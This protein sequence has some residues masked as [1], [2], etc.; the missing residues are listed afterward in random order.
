MR[1]ILRWA[2]INVAGVLLV[3]TS[4]A[5]QE[6]LAL[7]LP[8]T[9]DV[10]FDNFLARRAAAYEASADV[11]AIDSFIELFAA[12]AVYEVR[13][14]R[15]LRSFGQTSDVANLQFTLLNYRGRTRNP[16]YTVRNRIDGDQIVMAEV[17][18]S[19]EW[20][21]AERW[22]GVRVTE[23]FAVET[24]SGKIQRVIQHGR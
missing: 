10:V 13:P 21:T 17:E 2:M 4:V 18:W 12:E 8:P 5:A 1:I 3:G 9:A 7:G 6:P 11:A 24:R 15:S 19:F 16:A 22:G 14:G 20:R 23:L